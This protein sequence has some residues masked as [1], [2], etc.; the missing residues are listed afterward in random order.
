MGW[1]LYL[2]KHN[3]LCMG[4]CKRYDDVSLYLSLIEA[5]AKPANRRYDD[6]NPEIII[7]SSLQ[8]PCHLFLLYYVIHLKLRPTLKQ[9]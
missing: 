1:V 3:A 9:L 6:F 4:D 8:R 5:T 7:F 2:V